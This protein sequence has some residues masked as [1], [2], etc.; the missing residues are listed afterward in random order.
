MHHN[1]IKTPSMVFLE[2]KR[3][4]EEKNGLMPLQQ[5]APQ[6]AGVKTI[7]ENPFSFNSSVGQQTPQSA[8]VML[9]SQT[10]NDIDDQSSEH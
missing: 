1:T 7:G 5:I 9:P 2:N 4:E 8:L 6:S 10:R 3:R